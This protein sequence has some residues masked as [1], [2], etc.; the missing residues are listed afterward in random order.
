MNVSNLKEGMVVKNYRRLCELLE[1][2]VKTGGAKK[3]QLDK[4]KEILEFEKKGNSFLILKIKKEVNV[5]DIKM[6]RKSLYQDLI[7][8]ILCDIL[9][10]ENSNSLLISKS[11]L[12]KKLAFVNDN[13][14]IGFKNPS[15][16]ANILNVSVENIKDFYNISNARIY[17]IINR[18]L[19]E[20]QRKRII[21]YEIT[22]MV[23]LKGENEYRKANEFD[24]LK[25]LTIDRMVLDKF[26]IESVDD[27]SCLRG[28][29]KYY[30]MKEYRDSLME[31]S[32][33]EFQYKAFD[34]VLLRNSLVKN[35]EKMIDS[36]INNLE[37]NLKKQELNSTYAKSIVENA[38]KR[39]SKA[40]DGIRSYDNYVLDFSILAS[41][42]VSLEAENITYTD[43]NK[44]KF[45]QGDLDIDDMLPF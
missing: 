45:N 43:L 22:T 27:I 41:Q 39:H 40:K 21:D 37:Y 23:K 15:K 26:E 11:S 2:P 20:L 18:S 12:A 6:G 35:K 4:V 17:G 10:R 13:Y 44:I 8:V 33:I 32:H 28:T 3:N 1:I 31:N 30:E 14:N 25:L 29:K 16:M 34:I 7:E 36:V 9:L 42:L 38:Q 5:V 19:S 24:R